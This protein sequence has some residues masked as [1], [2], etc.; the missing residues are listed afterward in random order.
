VGDSAHTTHFTIG[1]G[2]KLAMEDAVALAG[3]LQR[4]ADLHTALDAYEKERKITLLQA[5]S[6]SRLSARWFED[7]SRYIDLEPDQFFALLRERRSPLLPHMSPLVYFRLHRA[8]E[9]AVLRELRRRVG[10]TA[11]AL[12]SRR[13]AQ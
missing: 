9:T 12:Y 7:I 13:K 1:S 3:K 4:H 6:E 2:T 8:M 5:H 11:R 10:P